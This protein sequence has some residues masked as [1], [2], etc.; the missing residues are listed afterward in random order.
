MTNMSTPPRFI[1]RRRVS[2][3]NLAP[4]SPFSPITTK[5][6]LAVVPEKKTL[7]FV[8]SNFR[9]LFSSYYFGFVNWSLSW[10]YMDYRHCFLFLC[11]QPTRRDTCLSDGYRVVEQLPPVQ[12][13][14]RK[15]LK[16]ENSPKIFWQYH[17]LQRQHWLHLKRRRTNHVVINLI[18]LLCPNKYHQ[19]KAHA[20][21]HDGEDQWILVSIFQRLTHPGWYYSSEQQNQTQNPSNGCTDKLSSSS[22]T[23]ERPEIWCLD[24]LLRKIWLISEVAKLYRMELQKLHLLISLQAF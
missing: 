5:Y 23:P 12:M 6:T 1:V 24:Q 21:H 20:G 4:V 13:C 22:Q 18:F 15:F 11:T 16:H 14:S 19:V 9:E 8:R 2:F 17:I 7:Y 10:F 3:S